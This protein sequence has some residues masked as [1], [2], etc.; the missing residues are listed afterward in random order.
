MSPLKPESSDLERVWVNCSGFFTVWTHELRCRRRC[1]YVRLA[2]GERRPVTA[3]ED[4]RKMPA[5]DAGQVVRRV[6]GGRGL[7]FGRVKVGVLLEVGRQRYLFFEPEDRPR[8][9]CLPRKPYN[10]GVCR[11]H[12]PVSG[13]RCEIKLKKPLPTGH[14][15]PAAV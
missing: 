15:K 7:F 3:A 11:G 8:F 6:C 12:F 13:R 14:F 1:T 9:R 10:N 4:R 2:L 5:R